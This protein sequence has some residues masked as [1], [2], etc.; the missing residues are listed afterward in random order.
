[1]RRRRQILP[2]SRLWWWRC[3]VSPLLA[4]FMF[5]NMHRQKQVALLGAA[6]SVLAIGY[7]IAMT[8][9]PDSGGVE[10]TQHFGTI[11]PAASALADLRYIRNRSTSVPECCAGWGRWCVLRC[12]RRLL[13]RIT[14]LNGQVLTLQH[15]RHNVY[16]DECVIHYLNE[17]TTTANRYS[18]L[19][20]YK[21]F[22]FGHA[23]S[24][25]H[26]VVYSRVRA[27]EQLSLKS[28]ADGMVVCHQAMAVLRKISD[29]YDTSY[30]FSADYLWVC[31]DN[32]VGGWLR[33]NVT[34]C[35][36]MQNCRRH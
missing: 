19:E 29:R 24:M 13:W 10:I 31:P 27:P 12:G 2:D 28:F 25:V 8:Y 26:G 33:R 15:S 9:M 18:S 30:R 17:G 20:E 3:P 36:A 21:I 22:A 16:L 11:W 34:G 32:R 4:I 23:H 14:Y 7:S 5:R 35:R 1:M 6:M